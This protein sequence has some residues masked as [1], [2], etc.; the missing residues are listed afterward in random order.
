MMITPVSLSI[1]YLAFSYFVTPLVNRFLKPHIRKYLF[2]VGVY[3]QSLALY[4]LMAFPKAYRL[5]MRRLRNEKLYPL[6]QRLQNE[7]DQ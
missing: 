1:A 5:T 2:P 4:L 6:T 7:I 3:S